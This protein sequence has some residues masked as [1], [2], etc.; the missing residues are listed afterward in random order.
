ME[1]NIITL[2]QLSKII[3]VFCKNIKVVLCSSK[4][5][6]FEI[7]RQEYFISFKA[8]SRRFTDLQSYKVFR[9]DTMNDI[10]C[11]YIVK[12]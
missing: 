10:I 3:N 2:E 9:I 6:G 12:I 8:I 4:E 11:V 1:T 5:S 7:L